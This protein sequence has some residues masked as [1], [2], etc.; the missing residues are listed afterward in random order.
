MNEGG[1]RKYDQEEILKRLEE[2]PL[3]DHTPGSTPAVGPTSLKE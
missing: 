2:N 1:K 3:R